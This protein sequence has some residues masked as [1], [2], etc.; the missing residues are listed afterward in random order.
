MIFVGFKQLAAYLARIW[1]P[2]NQV[3]SS[4][5]DRCVLG[6]DRREVY[7]ALV[8]GGA[9]EYC[10]RRNIGFAERKNGRR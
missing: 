9:T 10:D 3:L 2:Q 1:E 4:S 5:V 6:V 8:Y 7:T